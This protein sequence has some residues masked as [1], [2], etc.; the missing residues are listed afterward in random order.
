MQRQGVQQDQDDALYLSLRIEENLR[1]QRCV[2]P[3]GGRTKP[4]AQAG[5]NVEDR[6]AVV[7]R[8]DEIIPQI[9]PGEAMGLN[10]GEQSRDQISHESSFVYAADV[11]ML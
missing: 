8:V 11:V 6:L 9:E 1:A 5:G 10:I 3:D 2:S 4:A 7:A